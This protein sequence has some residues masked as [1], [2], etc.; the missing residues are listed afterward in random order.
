[1]SLSNHK[2]FFKYVMKQKIRKSLS[3]EIKD[4]T[5]ITSGDFILLSTKNRGKLVQKFAL[6]AP[7]L[8]R[9]LTYVVYLLANNPD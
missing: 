2:D 6:H 3:G 5:N 1:M 8:V 7:G 9:S 4:S